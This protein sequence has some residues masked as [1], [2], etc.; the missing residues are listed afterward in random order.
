M[1]HSITLLNINPQML[2]ILLNYENKPAPGAGFEPARAR[3][4]LALPS[5][6]C[7]RSRNRKRVL[8]S[9]QL[10]RFVRLSV[11]SLVSRRALWTGLSHPGIHVWRSIYFWLKPFKSIYRIHSCWLK[12]WKS[13]SHPFQLLMA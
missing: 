2:S 4:P 13:S 11:L 8:T 3:G 7:R 6:G 5:T 9:G 10:S 12:R 1:I